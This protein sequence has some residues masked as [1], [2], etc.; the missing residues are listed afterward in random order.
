[1][2]KFDNN[3]NNH[4]E[5]YKK[6]VSKISQL[7]KTNNNS[8]DNQNRPTIGHNTYINNEKIENQYNQRNIPINDIRQN[9]R[10]IFEKMNQQLNNNRRNAD[11]GENQQ[12]NIDIKNNGKNFYNR[13]EIDKNKI[14]IDNSFG[15]KNTATSKIL[16]EQNYQYQ[17]QY[18]NINIPTQ[19]NNH[20]PNYNPFQRPSNSTYDNKINYK[21][22]DNLNIPIKIPEISKNKRNY[23]S[24]NSVINNDNSNNTNQNILFFNSSGGEPNS[25]QKNSKLCS[26]LL[27][28][29]IFG[30]L[31][32]ILLWLKHPRVR[33]YLKA[34][35][36]NINSESILNFFKSFLHPIDLIKSIGENL[37]SF[38]D[39]LKES[40]L[41]L[42]QF[43]EDYS[44]L[45]RL[46]GIIVMVFVLWLIIKKIIKT[47]KPSGK[48]YIRDN[49]N[50]NK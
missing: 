36:H 20:H 47:I 33:E 14:L 38:K 18:N 13:N 27:Y 44:D 9:Q 49:Q 12:N 15:V 7:T 3:N 24:S 19:N 32:T 21:N 17:H 26:S 35:Y 2:K 45:W 6:L 42:Y 48:N 37:A 41:Y 11:W 34:S 39:V 16:N 8:F 10:L 46:L 30:S 29:L 31:G 5:T 23:P 28:G 4:L 43:I 22:D 25:P 40:L 1:M 50:Y